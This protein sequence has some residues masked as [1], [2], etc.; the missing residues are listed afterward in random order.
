MRVQN[1]SKER[2]IEN[3]DKEEKPVEK[4]LKGRKNEFWTS[5]GWKNRE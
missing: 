4:L 5:F 2:R 1:L 3:N